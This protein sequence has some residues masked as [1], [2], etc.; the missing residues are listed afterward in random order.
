[1]A[2]API[3]L[4]VTL[5]NM[6]HAVVA[7]PP[8]FGGKVKS[9]DAHRSKKIPRSCHSEQIPEGVAV[10][11]QEFLALR[12]SPRKAKCLWTTAANAKSS[13]P[14]NMLADFSK[15][16]ANPGIVGEKRK[17]TPPPRSKARPKLSL[18]NMTC[19]IS[20]TP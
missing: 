8:V 12:T 5:P 10:V 7:R 20:L 6:V 9:V 16:S 13:P 3:G 15:Q 4:D 2:T 1:M 17:A 11:R 18:P 14:T 19:P